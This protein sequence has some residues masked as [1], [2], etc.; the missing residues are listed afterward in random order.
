MQMPCVFLWKWSTVFDNKGCVLA[1][2]VGTVR[3]Q[4]VRDLFRMDGDMPE[5]DALSIKVV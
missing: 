2:E 4:V 1:D 3:S 5:Q